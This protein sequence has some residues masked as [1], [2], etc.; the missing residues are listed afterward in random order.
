MGPIWTNYLTA[1]R[2]NLRR[3]RPLWWRD[4]RSLAEFAI[5]ALMEPRTSVARLLVV[6]ESVAPWYHYV[7]GEIRSAFP[8]VEGFGRRMVFAR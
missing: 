6:D 7:A 5:R 2:Q 4:L 1:A 3:R 8:G